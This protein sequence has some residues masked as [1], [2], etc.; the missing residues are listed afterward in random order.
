MIF[1]ELVRPPYRIVYRITGDMLHIV[2]VFHSAR[3]IP[4]IPVRAC[5][6]CTAHTDVCATRE[7]TF[8]CTSKTQKRL[9]ISRSD[10]GDPAVIPSATDWH[11]N[12]LTLAHRPFFLF[13]HT[14]SLF[15]FLMPA[16]GNSSPNSFVAG[17]RQQALE[18]L[19]AEGF[20][21]QQV[22]KVLDGGPDV[23]CAATDR[24][25]LG[26]M[27]DLAHEPVRRRGRRKRR[28]DANT[29]RNQRIA[30]ERPRHGQSSASPPRPSG[31][32]GYGMT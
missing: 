13:A 3:P 29:P 11:C 1:R 25:V 23:F 4:Q 7:M 5:R 31:A 27:V 18:A 22:W 2:T 9:G 16:A 12:M 14:L 20:A 17:F 32:A 24:R 15:A 28:T 10:L 21:V 30:D 19:E 6:R 8:R 26:C